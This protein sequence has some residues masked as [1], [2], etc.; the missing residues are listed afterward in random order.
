MSAE[1]MLSA[2]ELLT[3]MPEVN[4]CDAVECYYNRDNM[5]HANAVTIGSGC[6]RCDTFIASDEHGSPASMGRVGACHEKDCNFND[7]LS[8]RAPGIDVGRHM[9]HGDCLTYAAG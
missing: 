5:C 8:C 3:K 7:Q 4:T 6:P 9:D 1:T 2:E